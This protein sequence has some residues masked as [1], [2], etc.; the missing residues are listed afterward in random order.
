VKNHIFCKTVTLDPKTTHNIPFER[1]FVWDTTETAPTAIEEAS[2]RIEKH[3]KRKKKNFE[4]NVLL[5]LEW[6][7]VFPLTIAQFSVLDVRVIVRNKFDLKTIRGKSCKS[8]R[9]G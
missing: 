5:C 9:G 8:C 7:G 3:S 4:K 2:V 6:A 1:L